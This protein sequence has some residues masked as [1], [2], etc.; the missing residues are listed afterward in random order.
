PFSCG[1]P[2]SMQRSLSVLPLDID[3]AARADAQ[4]SIE[5]RVEMWRMLLDEVPHYFWLG[6]GYAI[7]PTDIYLMDQAVRHGLAGPFE[8]AMVSGDY[9]SGPLSV[10]IPFGI[11]GVTAF[12]AFL[13]ASFR[14]IILNYR[15]GR[16]DISN[17]NTFV[18]S[19]FTAKVIFYFF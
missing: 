10:L 4:A 17:I 5:W 15:Y 19:Y 6:K 1:L 7:N 9:H 16:P 2:L 3:P 14:V 8:G 12:M 13:I 18:L 11:F